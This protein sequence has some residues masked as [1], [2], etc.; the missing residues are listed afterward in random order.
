MD[1]PCSEAFGSKGAGKHTATMPHARL[2]LEPRLCNLIEDDSDD[3][4][5]D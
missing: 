2:V 5:A 1:R 3:G 4:G